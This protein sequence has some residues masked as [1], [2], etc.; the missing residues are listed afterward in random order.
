MVLLS[1]LKHVLLLMIFSSNT[2]VIARLAPVP[3]R[4]TVHSLIA[5]ASVRRWTISQ[6]HVKNAFLHGELYEEV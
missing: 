2:V 1:A 3:H 5:V 6:L 4:T